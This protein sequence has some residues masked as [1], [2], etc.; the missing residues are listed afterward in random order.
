MTVQIKF[1]KTIV[2]FWNLYLVNDDP[3][4][5]VPVTISPVKMSELFADVSPK[6]KLGCGELDFSQAL[7]LFGDSLK[8]ARIA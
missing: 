3:T 4:P 1:V 8:E 2:G 7:Q 5:P 6:A